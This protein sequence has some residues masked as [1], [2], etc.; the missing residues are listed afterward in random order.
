MET[1]DLL[2]EV[3]ADYDGTVLIVSHDRD[4]LDRTVTVTLG[5]DGSGHVDIVAGGY[6]DWE[7]KRKPRTAA[8]KSGGGNAAPPPPPPVQKPTKLSYKD[9]RDY[10]LLPKRIEEIDAA[11]ARDEAALADPDL[12][13]RDPKRFD[14]LMAAIAQ[15]RE[16]KDSAELRWLELA[17]QVEALG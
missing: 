5:L 3:I 6:E 9:Q 17:E 16:E 4:F 14:A 12:Y 7:R 10:D 11:I 15:A 1:L 13:A 2:Q 8:R